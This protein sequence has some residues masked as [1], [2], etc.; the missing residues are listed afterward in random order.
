MR[1][2]N[3]G[4]VASVRLV[5]DAADERTRCAGGCKL[6]KS[7]EIDSTVQN[8]FSHSR[9]FGTFRVERQVGRVAVNSK[10]WMTV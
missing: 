6:D 7:D 8:E 4:V 9:R 2:R 1:C 5:R 3:F 10:S